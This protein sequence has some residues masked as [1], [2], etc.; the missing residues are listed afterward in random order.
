MYNELTPA[1]RIAELQNIIG[2]L[3]KQIAKLPDFASSHAESI[4]ANSSFYAR[5][6]SSQLAQLETVYNSIAG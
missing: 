4:I 1:E 6:L 2:K 3:Q 5:E